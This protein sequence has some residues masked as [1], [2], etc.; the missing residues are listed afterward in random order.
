MTKEL[1]PDALWAEVRPLLPPHPSHPKGGNDF[2][3]DRLCLR[4]LIFILKSGIK[5]NMLP[6]EVFGVSG[7]TCWRRMRDWT[8][9]GVWPALHHRLLNHL[10]RLEKVD[11][12]HAVIDSASVRAEKGGA[13][14]GRAPST[15]EKTA[16]NA[17]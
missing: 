1:L 10:G 6:T 12:A 13:T 2:A 3:D 8:A 15:A 4:G 9:A 7:V 16:A 11:L 17:T 14:P 5:Y